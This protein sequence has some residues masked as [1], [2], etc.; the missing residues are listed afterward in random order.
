MKRNAYSKIG[1]AALLIVLSLLFGACSEISLFT[2][3]VNEQD[4][5]FRMS[6]ET[7]NVRYGETFYVKAQGGFLPYSFTTTS[8]IGTLDISTGLYE[9]PNTV[10]GLELVEIESSDRFGSIDTMKI[11]L[12][13][14]LE[15]S[16]SSFSIRM[17]ETQNFDVSGGYTD[18]I[19][20]AVA[21]DYGIITPV[22][23][24]T[25]TYE[26][27]ST[28]TDYI[29]ITDEI[30]NSISITV[31]V[32][33]ASELEITP[34]YAVIPPGPG[35]TQIFTISGGTGTFPD[36]FTVT[37][38]DAFGSLEPDPLPNPFEYTAPVIEGAVILSVTDGDGTTVTAD[39]YVTA[40]TPATLTINPSYVEALPGA[41]L[42]FT[43]SGGIPPYTFKEQVG[44]GNLEVISATSVRYETNSPPPKAKIKVTD[45]AGATALAN[46]SMK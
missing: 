15:A 16:L 41:I 32:L 19:G 33:T 36:D 45:D 12:Y 37:L 11:K 29:E 3:L 38:S 40:D 35:S 25:F 27:V 20:Y 28:G 6:Q 46:I 31:Q 44:S 43:A 30:N 14:H 39:I 2:L 5:D 26:P 4:G 24:D 9:A 10:G 18:A 17:G 23:S 34:T 42:E 1:A 7:V 21:A 8:S 22:D 13:E